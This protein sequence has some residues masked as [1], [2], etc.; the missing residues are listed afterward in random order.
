MSIVVAVTESQTTVTTTENVSVLDTA[1]ED[2]QVAT[3]VG[4]LTTVAETDL[5]FTDVTTANATTT[6]HGLLKKLSGT[7]SDVFHGDGTYGAFT[8]AQLSTSD[9]T[10]NNASTSKHG[11]MPK[12][13]GNAAHYFDGTGAFSTPAGG[14]G[15]PWPNVVDD[16]GAAGDAKANNNATLTSGSASATIS[17]L[18][19]GD[20]GKRITFF[21][22]GV[23]GQF[24]WA[25]TINAVSGSTVTLAATAPASGS[26]II[27]V[28]GTDDTAAF[29]SMLSAAGTA[30]VPCYVPGRGT[31]GYLVTSTLVVPYG[32]EMFGD[33]ITTGFYGE[34]VGSRII[35]AGGY[36]WPVIALGPR[37]PNSATGE[38]F[39]TRLRN[40]EVWCSFLPGV[41]GVFTNKAQ[42]LSG[43]RDVGVAFCNHW[44][45]HFAKP[46]ST[47]AVNNSLGSGLYVGLNGF[48]NAPAYATTTFTGGAPTIA[49]AGTNA[50]DA[51]SN[52]ASTVT[53]P[54]QA[55]G[56]VT[57]TDASFVTGLPSQGAVICCQ[58]SNGNACVIYYSGKSGSTIT[59]CY[60]DTQAGAT[61]DTAKAVEF[62]QIG[63]YV[64]SAPAFR[65]VEDWTVNA[66]SGQS[67]GIGLRV[68]G[69]NGHYSRGHTEKVR[70]GVMLGKS[71]SCNGLTLSGVQ[72]HDSSSASCVDLVHIASTYSAN[73]HGGIT[74][75]AIYNAAAYTNTL[76]DGLNGYTVT[77]TQDSEIGIYSIGSTNS[78]GGSGGKPIITDISSVPVRASQGLAT[79]TKAG[80]VVDGD[81]AHPIDGLVAVDTTNKLLSFRANSGWHVIGTQAVTTKTANYTVTT[82]DDV[83]HA[84]ATSGNVT[85][86]LYTAVGNS[87]R[88]VTVKRKDSSG[89]TV[90]VATASGG[91]AIDGSTSVSLASQYSS[92]TI[93]SNNANWLKI[94]AV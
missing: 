28:Y 19:A 56:V 78:S 15:S 64:Q 3:V 72:S 59:G 68:D 25:T 85:I 4:G 20:V 23:A 26:S 62:S 48:G 47:E 55:T 93:V 1:L 91:E 70:Y 45:F 43:V 81:F 27:Y 22:Q 61:L 67:S 80:V 74:L 94:A 51:S 12:L 21:Y 40:M 53:S 2:V 44:A 69:G 79:L 57:L 36:N 29:Q 77:K 33:G 60:T 39:G 42:E 31:F 37:L 76:T 46:L 8:D 66:H 30:G 84:D 38:V 92:L 32:V 54:A 90:S 58:T 65:G 63:I 52:Y 7:V 87:G 34:V 13:D 49:A 5:A 83:I 73:S 75:Q 10:T 71:Q 6:K 89:N 86:T 11:F 24:G 16:Y 50:W 14:S 41:V 17:G 35:A 82:N 9:V 18:S 88:Q